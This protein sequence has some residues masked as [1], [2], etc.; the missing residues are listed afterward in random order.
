MFAASYL[1]YN[2]SLECLTIYYIRFHL[3]FFP[4][5]SDNLFQD[6]T[7]VPYP[8][9]PSPPIPGTDTII[10]LT[11]FWELQKESATQG[12]CVG[13]GTNY[14]E[15]VRRRANYIYRILAPEPHTLSI[16]RRGF[17]VWV[18]EEMKGSHNTPALPKARKKAYSHMTSLSHHIRSS[19]RSILIMIRRGCRIYGS[20]I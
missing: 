12:N 13:T 19:S 9:F 10:P 11:S 17:D 14:A 20:P 5:Q 8:P 16:G 2:L 4:F 18:I 3:G 1:F 6:A 15:R 7:E